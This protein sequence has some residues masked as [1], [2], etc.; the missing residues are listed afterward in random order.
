ME[1][2]GAK[3]LLAPSRV[4]FLYGLLHSKSGQSFWLVKHGR[5]DDDFWGLDH[6]GDCGFCLSVLDHSLWGRQVPCHED[7]QAVLSS[8]LRS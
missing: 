6:K 4:T 8:V 5:S 1:T 7:E 2:N 3:E